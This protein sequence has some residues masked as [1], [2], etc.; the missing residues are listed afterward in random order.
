VWTRWIAGHN[1]SIQ[2]LDSYGIG[3]IMK[4]Q[5][6]PMSIEEWE[7]IAHPFGWKVE[8]W[9]GQA[10][11]SPRDHH[12]RSKLTLEY[13][14]IEGSWEIVPFDQSFQSRAIE[15]FFEAFQDSV[16]F[17]DWPTATIREHITKNVNSYF[18]GVRGKPLPVSVVALDGDRTGSPMEDRLVG[19]ALFVEDK[20]A[21]TVLDLLFVKPQ[22]QRMGIAT[23]M[24]TIAANA[25]HKNGVGELYCDRHI[26]N[27]HSHDWQRQYGFQE[28]PDPF[29]CRLK[30]S[31]YRNE[32]WRREKLGQTEDL[33]SLQIARDR[34]HDLLE[35]DWKDETTGAAREQKA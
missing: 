16:E 34:W 9:D 28:I 30:Y 1:E 18:Q 7:L 8:Y 32:I 17:C 15:V 21:Q 3:K 25:L 10:Q 4:S 6:I 2:Q 5:H 31:W 20:K 23:Q 11:L 12:V 27:D 13:R 14:E 35:N 33:E 24:V 22:Y 26:C 29:Y 19:L